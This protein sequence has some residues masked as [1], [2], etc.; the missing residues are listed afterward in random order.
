MDPADGVALLR[1]FGEVDLVTG[2]EFAAHLGEAGRPGR[3]LI[4]DLR[5]VLYIDVRGVKALE[6]AGVRAS[7]AGQRL[8]VVSSNP[9]F[10]KL[11]SILQFDGQVDLVTT[12]DDARR[13]LGTAPE[14]GPRP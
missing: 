12:V 9:L 14:T 8:I 11:F 13:L 7:A 1:I 10:H 5:G 3:A 4:V 2:D 6:D